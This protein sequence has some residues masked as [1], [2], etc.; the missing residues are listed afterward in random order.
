MLLDSVPK[1]AVKTF[2]LI[3]EKKK[4]AE[5]ALSGEKKIF[6][7]AQI[8]S[9]YIKTLKRPEYYLNTQELDLAA[10]IFDKKLQVVHREVEGIV[11]AEMLM[12][13]T[14]KGDPKGNPIVIFHG[15]AHFERC[16]PS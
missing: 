11:P 10:H 12:N 13:E 8:K 9:L 1:N 3:E 4:E 14:G 6:I 15:N 2:L 7:L 16:I 5:I